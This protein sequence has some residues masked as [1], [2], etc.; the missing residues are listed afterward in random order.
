MRS[1]IIGTVALAFLD[2]F[3]AGRP[4]TEPVSVCQL[5]Q[6]E[7]INA[8]GLGLLER[9]KAQPTECPAT[10]LVPDGITVFFCG[11]LPSSRPIAETTAAIDNYLL[12]DLRARFT[13]K[14][15]VAEKS[16]SIHYY[17][18]RGVSLAVRV[19]ADPNVL[20][21]S[22][23]MQSF[24]PSLPDPQQIG[25]VLAYPELISKVAPQFPAR[26]RELRVEADL[27]FQTVLGADGRIGDMC[28]LRS[29]PPDLGFE[30]AAVVAL[31]KWRYK[32]ARLNDKPIPFPLTVMV[33]F[34]LH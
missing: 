23:P 20:V 11:A 26:A 24:A 21:L 18:I 34:R 10:V 13:E 33:D 31:R 9:L 15:W 30:R 27:L 19:M 25:E 7:A 4:K 16:F 32:P 14:G 3:G 17:S 28:V 1:L 2:G 22:Y 29:P 12:E 6:V 8:L 5:K